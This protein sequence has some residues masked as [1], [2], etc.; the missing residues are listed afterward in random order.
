[1]YFL[2]FLAV[3]GLLMIFMGFSQSMTK[4]IIFGVIILLTVFVFILQMVNER[5]KNRQ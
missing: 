2:I 4:A 1:M 5:N 3:L